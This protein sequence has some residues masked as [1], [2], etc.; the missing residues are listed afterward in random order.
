MERLQCIS[1]SHPYPHD[2]FLECLDLNCVLTHHILS[3][4][5]HKI[6]DDEEKLW[7]EI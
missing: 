2:K 4:A 5:M 1:L 6:V 3:I 7:I